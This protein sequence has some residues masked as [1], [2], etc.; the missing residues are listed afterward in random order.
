MDLF[1]LLFILGGGFLFALIFMILA[2]RRDGHTK[3]VL[4]YSALALVCL[5]VQHRV[6]RA[7][8]SFGAAFGT[9]YNEGGEVLAKAGATGVVLWAGILLATARKQP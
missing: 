7:S 1:V 6:S 3:S 8:A 5:F 9:G 4:L 2:T